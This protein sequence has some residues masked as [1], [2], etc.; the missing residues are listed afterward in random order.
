MSFLKPH[1]ST[2]KIHYHP[3]RSWGKVIFSQASVILLMGGGCAIP[4]CIAGGIPACLA[5][6][7]QVGVCSGGVSAPGDALLLWP[8]VVVFCYALLLWPSGLVAIWLKA[9][10]WYGL[11]GGAEGHNRRPPHQKATTERKGVPGGDTHP[12]RMATAVGS[13][14]PTGMHSC[15]CNI[16]LVKD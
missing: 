16:V 5:A 1:S 11:L 4:E 8:S 14:H 3:Q 13:M 6:G 12:P 10:F 15:F 7:L 9:A 2:L